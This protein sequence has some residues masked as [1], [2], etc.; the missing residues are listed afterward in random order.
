[1]YVTSSSTS[2]VTLLA[3]HSKVLF[4]NNVCRGGKQ[5]GTVFVVKD[6]QSTTKHFGPQAP[7]Y[8]QRVVFLNNT[9]AIGKGVA[10]QPT[11]LRITP[12][13]TTIVVTDY[14]IFLRP[15]LVFSLVDDFNNVNTTDFST[16]VSQPLLLYLPHISFNHLFPSFYPVVN[17][18]GHCDSTELPL[19]YWSWSFR[20]F[21]WRYD[22]GSSCGCSNV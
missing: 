12:N 17:I 7:Y 10:T 2:S 11:A 9:A 19:R 21:E 3:S 8:N 4:R 6:P 5:G 22:S 16:M 13:H 20:I 14:N 18:S 15:S 1:M